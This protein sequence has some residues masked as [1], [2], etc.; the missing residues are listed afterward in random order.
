MMEKPVIFEAQGSFDPKEWIYRYKLIAKV[1]KWT[2]TDAIELIQLYLGKKEL[3]WYK[4][5]IK[6]FKDWDTLVTKF[7]EKYSSKEM[8][9]VYW[10]KIQMIKQEDFASIE[11]FEL[12]LEELF[13]KAEVTDEGVKWNCLM[14]A[15][16][17]K[18]KRKV[19]ESDHKKWADTIKLIKK[20]EQI[21]AVV[22]PKP[23]S[24]KDRLN[25]A[26]KRFQ[27]SREKFEQRNKMKEKAKQDNDYNDMMKQFEKL[28][29]NVM[30]KVDEVVDRR[31]N[32]T[33]GRT[34]HDRFIPTCYHCGRKGHRKYECRQLA[35]EETEYETSSEDSDD[36]NCIEVED[37]SY[38]EVY[39][40]DRVDKNKPA[41]GPYKKKEHLNINIKKFEV[42]LKENKIK[43]TK[44]IK[45]NKT[46]K[47]IEMK[48][49]P[50]LR[51][52][53]SDPKA[54]AYTKKK[55][56][57]K[58]A[59][60]TDS[61]SLKEDLG[62][63]FPKISMIQLLEASPKLAKEMV[64]LCK[65]VED[66]EVNEIKY[67]ETKT[68]NCKVTVEVFGQ[69][70][71]TILD[72]GAA[73]SV[74]TPELVENWGLEVERDTS[75]M[76]ITADG[77]KH[78]S[79]G[80]VLDVPIRIGKQVFNADL[81][82][83][84]RYDQSLILGTDWLVR[85]KATIDLE[86][87]QLIISNGGFSVHLPLKTSKATVLTSYDE[88]E[89]RTRASSSGLG[90]NVH[91]HDRCK[92][93]EWTWSETEEKALSNLKQALL[94]APV[95]AH[96]DWERMFIVT[97]DAS[98]DGIGA[99]ISQKYESGERPI[100]Y[101]SR[102]TT[103]HERN[104][105]ISHLEGLAVVWAVVKFKY[106]IWGR[107]FIIKTDHK[108]L[109]NLF[110]GKELTGRVARWAMLLRNYDYEIQHLPGKKNPADS[111]SRLSMETATDEEEDDA[112]YVDLNCLEIGEYNRIID[113]LMTSDNLLENQD[114][115]RSA[116]D[117]HSGKR[118]ILKDGELYIKIG[119]TEKQ[120]LN[121]DNASEE[122]CKVHF[123]T[124]EGVENTFKR[125]KQR[126]YGKNLFKITQGVVRSCEVCQLFKGNKSRK[127]YLNTVEGNRPFEIW[128]IDAMGPI[129]P[130]S[131]SGN[132]YILT[133]VDYCT[134]WPVALPVPNLLS[135][136]I[137]NFIIYKIVMDYGVPTQLITDQGSS[138]MSEATK[139]VYK[140]LGIK[141]APT[142]G[143]RPQ[144]NG[145]V[146][147]LNRSIKSIMAKQID[148]DYLN[149]DTYLWKTLLILRTLSSKTTGFT[150]AELLYGKDLTMAHNW[151]PTNLIDRRN[152]LVHHRIE[153]LSTGLKQIRELGLD[154]SK[155]KKL[156]QKGYYDKKVKEKLFRKNDIVLKFIEGEKT[157]FQRI[158]K[159][160][161]K[162]EK[163][164]I[165]GTYVIV[166]SEG[167]SELVNGDTLKLFHESN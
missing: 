114:E 90:T 59:E 140:W 97:T 62:T 48:K 45:P 61:Y 8:N 28:S 100:A 14:N 15:L 132:R 2:D 139:A 20:S 165:N 19:L 27:D 106:Y 96:P 125:I 107:K 53:E 37:I 160:P 131:K 65:R 30:N 39:G 166:D 17:E 87:S 70:V 110:N 98:I 11:D 49:A 47:E 117:A 99:I 164:L 43:N 148:E 108:S 126:F 52:R 56:T 136:T 50:T 81:T 146:E 21:K 122:I 115:S 72:T 77:S 129:N 147:R 143:Y 12:E 26:R 22:K 109:L 34:Y 46:I 153:F 1:N 167:N 58:A 163:I 162:V 111:L 68:S 44:V 16:S 80:K 103:K 150:P 104:Y 4:K 3:Q 102:K 101:I 13:E 83:M 31:L 145:Q 127:N 113:N 6:E 33:R 138:F 93:K 119:N 142:S 135:S 137:I 128:G 35:Q 38:D 133:A 112:E 141:H 152:E 120:V 116:S 134:K 121:T 55:Y 24:S 71:K 154:N 74:A 105:S 64:N 161:Y 85:H 67:K 79:L 157:K 75:Q 63:V 144:S 156:K 95:L 41:I 54:K 29:V 123:E 23:L 18:N 36:L 10:K 82:V 149:W 25:E 151:T 159:G 130:V 84:D 60:N 42:K 155:V 76:I 7:T 92:N 5:N 9:F 89:L 124:H 91:R 118:Y 158:W 94:D 51:S 86:L 69:E 40:A 88:S 73:C 32:K 78:A 57:I 66:K